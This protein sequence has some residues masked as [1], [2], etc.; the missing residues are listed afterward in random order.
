LVDELDE[1]VPRRLAAVPL[2][3]RV[4]LGCFA[5]HVECGEEHLASLRRLL[6]AEEL[7][8]LIEPRQ[9]VLGAVEGWEEKLVSCLATCAMMSLV[10]VVVVLVV[11]R[12]ALVLTSPSF[13]DCNRLTATM[14]C[15]WF[16]CKV[17]K[18]AFSCSTW[19]SEAARP[20]SPVALRRRRPVSPF[21]WPCWLAGLRAMVGSCRLSWTWWVMGG[22]EKNSGAAVTMVGGFEYQDDMDSAMAMANRGRS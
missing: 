6:D 21:G 8:A 11:G 15:P 14:S 19:P 9:Q 3:E 5:R 7:V 1:F 18:E 10:P 22:R 12:D 17:A 2:K 13:L 4:P 20:V 16:P